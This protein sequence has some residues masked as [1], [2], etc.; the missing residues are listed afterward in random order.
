MRC[1][2]AIGAFDPTGRTGVAADLRVFEALGVPGLALVTRLQVDADDGAERRHLTPPRFL[3]AQLDALA[4]EFPIGAV[5]LGE[6][7]RAPHAAVLVERIR[8]RALP[9]VVMDMR[10]L[11]REG[12]A[13]L[14]N[15]VLALVREGLPPA[16]VLA[17]GALDELR[18]LAGAGDAA[19]VEECAAQCRRWGLPAVL[20]WK[21][22]RITLH[23]AAGPLVCATA[24]TGSCTAEGA[25]GRRGSCFSPVL[26]PRSPAPSAV[27]IS[28]ARA[29]CSAAVTAYL[30]R[31]ECLETAVRLA[32]EY[33]P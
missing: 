14:P 7:E 1:A 32:A 30:A 15:R 29:A 17:L 16:A 9:N 18:R 5:R 23:T 21:S 25:E 2:L 26:I 12:R 20:H 11:D 4:R 28:P 6:L 8:R 3:A 24:S 13:T 27:R 22:D 19:V 33:T 31:G 10:L